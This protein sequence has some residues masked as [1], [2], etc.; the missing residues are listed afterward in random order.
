MRKRIETLLATLI[1]LSFCLCGCVTDAEYKELASRVEHL[2][3]LHGIKAETTKTEAASTDSN[4]TPEDEDAIGTATVITASLNVRSTP[5]QTSPRLGALVNG[6][7]VD[8]MEITESGEWA[9]IKVDGQVGYVKAEFVKISYLD[10]N[11]ANITSSGPEYVEEVNYEKIEL[12]GVEI[13]YPTDGKLGLKKEKDDKYLEIESV[14]IEP[15]EDGWVGKI[16]F[17]LNFI[18]TN[19]YLNA[20]SFNIKQ[21]D[22]EGFCIAESSCRVSVVRGERVR[23]IGAF[24]LEKNAVKAIIEIKASDNVVY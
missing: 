13:T 20:V 15:Q 7:T 10:E 5:D 22:K 4:K 9:K 23:K 2:E 18:G 6:Q 21:Y 8:L 14:T 19:P 11:Y 16:N 3:S 1:I 12:A 17:R 24:Y